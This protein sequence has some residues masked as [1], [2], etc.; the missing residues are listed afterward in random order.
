MRHSTPES[1]NTAAGTVGVGPG[2]S[3]EN[4]IVDDAYDLGRKSARWDVSCEQLTSG[5]FS[6]RV[7]EFWIRSIQ[8]VQEA[9][10]Q[11]FLESGR[12]W[13]SSRTFAVFSPRGDPGRYFGAPLCGDR[14]CTLS[15]DDEIDIRTPAGFERTS[16]TIGAGVLDSYLSDREQDLLT[17]RFTHGSI[18]GTPAAARSLRDALSRILDTISTSPGV[19]SHVQARRTLERS[20]GSILGAVLNRR[21]YHIPEWLYHRL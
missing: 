13:S 20:G 14:V 5:R 11:A 15:S 8:V 10:N 16:V 12:S 4:W 2:C 9:C 7:C 18:V 21:H 1:P 3:I 17:S 6:G 19:L